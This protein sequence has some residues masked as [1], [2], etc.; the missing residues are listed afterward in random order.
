MRAQNTTFDSPEPSSPPLWVVGAPLPERPDPLVA[1]GQAQPQGSLDLS[2]ILA[3][4]EYEPGRL[5]VRKIMGDDGRPR[6]QVRLELGMMQMEVTGRPDG[7]RPHDSPSLLD[8]HVERLNAH[9]TRYGTELGFVLSPNDCRELRDEAAL[10]YHRYLGLFILGEY[11]ATIRDTARN[12]Q[13]ADFCARH[14]TEGH[15]GVAMEVYRP[16]LLMMHARASAGLALQEY[17]YRR[18]LRAIRGGLRRLRRHYRRFGGGRAWRGSAE[19]RVL[20]QLSS[21][22]SRLVPQSPQRRLKREL[23]RAIH[24][25][26]YERAA[27]LRDEIARL[28]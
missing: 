13:A 8:Y 11:L 24:R 3:G 23:E 10:Y 22:L 16:Y 25:E 6:L 28:G 12:L 7:K 17:D 19:V 4:W 1:P 26:Q 9:R 5:N 14:A 27:E 18:A 2:G 15:D 21:H 20:R